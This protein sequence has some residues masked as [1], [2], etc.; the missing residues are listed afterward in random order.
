M[1]KTEIQLNFEQWFDFH[2]EYHSFALYSEFK[3]YNIV[4]YKIPVTVLS[5]SKWVKHFFSTGALKNSLIPERN[6]L[7][8]RPSTLPSVSFLCTIS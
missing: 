6:R 3:I 2:C 7:I 5:H 4:L 1:P 8:L